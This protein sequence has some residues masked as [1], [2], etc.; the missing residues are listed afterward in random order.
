MEHTSPTTA[1]A[2][3]HANYLAVFAWLTGATVLEILISFMPDTPDLLG[4]KVALLVVFAIF[5]ATLVWLYYMHLLY[6][7]R[8][9]AAILIVG[10][11]FALLAGRFFPLILK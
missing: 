7:S 5:K 6:D 1:H 8:W 9:Y 4:I 11:I 3:P 2:R 10:V